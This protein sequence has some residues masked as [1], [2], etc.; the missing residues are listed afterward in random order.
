MN[1]GGEKRVLLS[2]MK[3][4]A[5]LLVL[6]LAL[7]GCPAAERPEDDP[8]PPPPGAAPGQT[9][10][11]T[12]GDPGAPELDDR[13]LGGT[14]TGVGDMNTRIQ[15]LA[16]EVTGV[17]NVVAVVVGNIALI[18]I[19]TNVVPNQQ[20]QVGE[21]SPDQ[22]ER[23]VADAVERDQTIVEAY[24]TSDRQLTDRIRNIAS[25]MDDGRPITQYLDDITDLLEEMRPRR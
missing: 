15:G 5:L 25:N 3:V 24:V 18:G 8:A 4:L 14:A 21:T 23:S 10:Q 9:P 2:K 16:Q 13:P 7:T 12:P 17:E 20:N 6:T 22:L 11:T 19:D 1:E